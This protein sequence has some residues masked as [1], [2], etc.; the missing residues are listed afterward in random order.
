MKPWRRKWYVGAVAK[1][2][3]RVGISRLW[4]DGPVLLIQMW[5][6]NITRHG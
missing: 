5:W 4:Y 1:G 2:Y 3:R 6:V